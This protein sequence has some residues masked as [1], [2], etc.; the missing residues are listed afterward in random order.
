M[1]HVEIRINQ[2]CLPKFDHFDSHD[3]TKVRV[4]L[5]SAY[6]I[7]IRLLYKMIN[8]RIS[9]TNWRAEVSKEYTQLTFVARNVAVKVP[10]LLGEEP[11]L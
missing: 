5:P 6:E 10:I 9:S 8:V 1:I 2:R 3:Q 11:L 4:V 7:G